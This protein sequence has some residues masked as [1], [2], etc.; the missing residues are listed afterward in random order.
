MACP[1]S[2]KTQEMLALADDLDRTWQP[3]G[4]YTWQEMADLTAAITN[5]SSQASSM[6]IEAFKGGQ[7][8]ALSKAVSN[9][10]SV[11]SLVQYYVEKWKEAKAA[12]ALV[13]APGFKAWCV[14]LLK[15]AGALMRAAEQAAC[16]RPGWADYAVGLVNASYTVVNVA[17]GVGRA[18]AS[19]GSAVVDAGKAAIAIWPVAKWVLLGVG[20]IFAGVYVKAKY[21]STLS[22]VRAAGNTPINWAS[23][24]ARIQRL[25]TRNKTV[26]GRRLL[27]G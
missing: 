9:Y 21:T 7:N 12:N 4:Y 26:A 22:R 27:R 11:S 15:A 5:V 1:T 18:V 8:A 25:A 2:A 19:V 17:K 24:K 13:S 3:T 10:T 16:D 20:V 23:I 14:S 6:A